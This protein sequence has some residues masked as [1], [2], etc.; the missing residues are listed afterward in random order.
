MIILTTAH[1]LFQIGK[2]EI[3]D[4]AYVTIVFAS[5]LGSAASAVL[6]IGVCGTGYLEIPVL[7]AAN[8]YGIRDLTGKPA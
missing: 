5:I 8:A 3:T 4:A 2:N 1:I 6:S 7:A